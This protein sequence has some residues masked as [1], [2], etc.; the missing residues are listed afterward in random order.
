M[1]AT[2]PAE[3]NKYMTYKTILLIIGYS[4]CFVAGGLGHQAGGW[5]GVVAVLTGMAGI[6]INLLHLIIEE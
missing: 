3:G 2:M 4:L 5:L 6:T 1:L